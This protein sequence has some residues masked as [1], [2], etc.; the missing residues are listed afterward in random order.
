M[1]ILVTGG[2]GFI[3][4][5]VVDACIAGG[6]HV[7]VL[8]DLS[9]G[10]I[11][12]IAHLLGHERFRFVE[13][14]IL[15]E[16]LVGQLVEACDEVYHLAAAIGMRRV[17]GMPLTTFKTNL[18]GSDVVFSAAALRGRRVLLASTS[19]VYGL[20]EHRPTSEMDLTVLG[21][22]TKPRWTYAYSK[23]AAEVLGLAYYF[24]ENLPL[25]IARLFNTVGPRQTGRYGMVVPTFVRQALEGQPLTVHGDGSQTRC[26]GDVH[27][28]AGA[29]TSLM[30]QPLAI[31]QVFNVGNN[32]ETSIQELAERVIELTGSSSSI[33]YVPHDEVY[34][35]NFDE[36]QRRVP[37]ISKVRDFIDF[38]PQTTIDDIIRGVIA[39]RRQK[40]LAI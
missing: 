17:V 33:V 8:D 2:A 18:N 4:S 16:R 15:N 22:T 11:D 26:F 12:N 20:N 38:E 13:G 37:D 40:V 10:R 30:H 23:A 5:H 32:Q 27:E 14:S 34:G 19:E 1:N 24:D 31:G 25:I 6:D 29:L 9:T 36:I 21:L 35:T 3:G 39:E 28:I 7:T